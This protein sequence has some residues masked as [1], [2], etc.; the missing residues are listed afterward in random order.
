MKKNIF[1]VG[2][3]IAAYASFTSN[4]VT[5]PTERQRSLLMAA[6]PASTPTGL[7]IASGREERVA[8]LVRFERDCVGVERRLDHLKAGVLVDK[9]QAYLKTVATVVC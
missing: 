1:V 9:G 2:L 7:P 3:A 4:I 5:H 6:L 8:S